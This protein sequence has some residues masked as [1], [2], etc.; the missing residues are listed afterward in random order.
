M[1]DFMNDDG[2]ENGNCPNSDPGKYIGIHVLF[3]KL[4]LILRKPPSG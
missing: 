3:P 1:S 4:Y 2:K